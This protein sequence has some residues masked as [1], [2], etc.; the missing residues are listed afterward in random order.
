MTVENLLDILESNV[1]PVKLSDE[2]CARFHAYDNSGIILNCG[3]QITGVLFTLDFSLASVS[4]ACE[5]GFNAI[6]TH[7]PAIYG[8]MERLDIVSDPKAKALALCM[9]SGVSVISMHLNFDAAPQGIDYNLMKGLGGKSELAVN[10]NLT[11]GG[12]GRV[13]EVEEEAFSDYVSRVKRAFGAERFLC[14]GDGGKIIKRVASFCGAGCDDGAINFAKAYGADAVVSSDMP[15]HRI[16]SLLENG[17]N[18]LQLTHYCAETY[19]MKAVYEKIKKILDTPSDYFTDA[20]F[21]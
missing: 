10:E 18:V 13:Y 12:Y 8:G 5:L 19:G 1:A 11:D 7:H 14:Y 21:M 2:Y 16:A 15:H 17:I 3:K 9:E 6:V 20:R 4:R